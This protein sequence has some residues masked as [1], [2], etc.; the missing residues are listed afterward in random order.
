MKGIRWKIYTDLINFCCFLKIVFWYYS[1]ITSFSLTVL[2][3]QHSYMPC[4][5]LFQIHSFCFTLIGALCMYVY[6]HTYIFLNIIKSMH[7]MLIVG[8][9][10]PD[11]P[12]D[13]R[14]S[15]GVLF[16]GNEGVSYSQHSLVASSSL[17]RVENSLSFLYFDM[18]I[19]LLVKL[20][21]K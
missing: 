7:I 16:P 1:T 6:I 8:L 5:A 11:W 17:W 20:T 9:F 13:I 10:F 3:P 2:S 19:A 4:H 15:V 18:S 21:F 12:F 14:Q